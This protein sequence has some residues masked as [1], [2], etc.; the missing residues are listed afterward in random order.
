MPVSLDTVVSTSHIFPH[1]RFGFPFLPLRLCVTPAW[2]A[3][4][5]GPEPPCWLALSEG[6]CPELQRWGAKAFG[7]LRDAELEREQT[8]R[9][10]SDL[11]EA[12]RVTSCSGP[13]ACWLGSTVDFGANCVDQPLQE[14]V[15]G[16]EL[17]DPLRR[18]KAPG[19]D[20]FVLSDAAATALV[21]FRLGL[22]RLGGRCGR[23]TSTTRGKKPQKPFCDCTN[24]TARHRV[25]CGCGPWARWRHDRLA[26]LLQLLILEIP[27]ASVRWTPRAGFW[28][29]GTRAGEPD[30]R[31][32]IPGWGTLYIDVAVTFPYPGPP[33]C[34]ASST[35]GDKET[36]YP[37]WCRLARVQ[38]VD[39][40]PCVMEA[41]GRFGPH[42]AALIRSL[43]TK[44]AEGW[45]LQPAVEARRWFSL[46]GR[47]LQLDQ[48]DILL[49]SCG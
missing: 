34:S 7:L 10:S 32:D 42:S 17:T 5:G 38:P 45:G 26:R 35:E 6:R 30:L 47:R 36:K 1:F 21:R 39:F 8:A 16:P 49:N 4:Q 3:A 9:A 46:L 33:G 28:P 23:K 25:T 29:Q 27:G 37:T 31:V 48:A 18:A 43:A 24:A 14:D 44:C 12:A 2:V 41:F 11:N 19:V 15:Q 40:Y 13:G 22:S 20:S